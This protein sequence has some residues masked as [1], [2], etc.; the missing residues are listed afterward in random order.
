VPSALL[1]EALAPLRA[2]SA[3]AAILLDVDGT[4]APIV[5][6]P[7]AARVPESTRELLRAVVDRYGLVA[8]VSGRQALEA[9]AI[10]G[11]DNITYIGAHGLERLDPGSDDVQTESVRGLRSDFFTTPLDPGVRI[12][13][14]G[15]I[16]AFHWRGA[17]DEAAAEASVRAAAQRGEAAGFRVHWGRKVMELRPPV[18]IDKGVA[19]TGLIDQSGSTAALYAGDDVTDIDAFRALHSTGLAYVVCVGVESA[20]QPAELSQESDL[21]V[22]GIE[23]MAEVLAG[24]VS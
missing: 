1:D 11:I 2:N 7:A 6:D 8:C 3:G 23:G 24:L 19:V 22:D 14:K 16:T 5:D 9:R 4:L 15:A 13:H 21:L 20:E 17:A 10:V 12:E 18:E